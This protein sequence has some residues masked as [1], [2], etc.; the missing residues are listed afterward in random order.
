MSVL[1][2]AVAAFLRSGIVKFPRALDFSD[3]SLLCQW[4]EDIL[5][6]L[7]GAATGLAAPTPT[8]KVRM[9]DFAPDLWSVCETLLGG[10]DKVEEAWLTNGVVANIGPN[11]EQTLG[12]HVDGDF[13]QHYLDSPEQGLLMIVL[14]TNVAD[15]SG[16]TLVLP[17]SVRPVAEAL[18]G[19]SGGCAQMSLPYPE[20]AAKHLSVTPLT[21]QA[22]DVFI[23]HPFMVHSASPM[24]DQGIRLISNP[25]IRRKVPFGLRDGG[26]CPV[27]AYTLSQLRVNSVD[28]PSRT[29]NDWVVPPRLR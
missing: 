27:S 13:F 10:T 11:P 6:S 17:D 9:R 5:D 18:H 3:G 20:I 26:D 23:M 19:A 7:A 12:W 16:P 25:V 24:V 21:G 28:L 2:D 22:G 1:V 29:T 15:T 14:W 4:R 8:Q